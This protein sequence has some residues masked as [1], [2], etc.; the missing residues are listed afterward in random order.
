LAVVDGIIGGEGNGPMA[1]DAKPCGAI[2]A[3]IH[4]LAVDCV[5]ATLMGFDWR[6]LRLLA[7]GFAM[8]QLNFVSFGPQDI[9]VISNKPAWSG[10]LDGMEGVIPFRPH[11]GWV[12]AIENNSRS[13]T[14]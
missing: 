4:P 14:A 7:N 9:N 2:I 11:F 12:G 1:P 5:A 3:G 10:N 6:R 13:V 8:K